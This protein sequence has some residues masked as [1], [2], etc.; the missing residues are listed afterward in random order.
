MSKKN[1][2]V[3]SPTEAKPAAT[4]KR[5]PI[6]TLHVEDVNCSIW[7]RE[8]EYQGQLRTFYSCTFEHSYKDRDG[9]YRYTK[10]F[11]LDSLGKIVELC[12]QASDW[13]SER[14]SDSADPDGHQAS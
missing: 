14:L 3:A 8:H 13:I 6:K 10:S 11:D 12:R 7:A 9:T 5:R 2:E 4:D 1:K